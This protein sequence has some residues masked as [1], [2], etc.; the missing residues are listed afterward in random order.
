M[1][2][3]IAKAKGQ[4][5][6]TVKRSSLGFD[7]LNQNTHKD[8][9]KQIEETTD[10]PDEIKK[11]ITNDEN[12]AAAFELGKAIAH[13]QEEKKNHPFST[14]LQLNLHGLVD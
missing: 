1:A 7:F 12:D 11:P 4:Q 5:P 14:G 3:A 13:A 2:N 8:I 10:I 9:Y 6:A